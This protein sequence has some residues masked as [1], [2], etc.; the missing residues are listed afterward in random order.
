VSEKGNIQLSPERYWRISVVCTPFQNLTGRFFFTR[1]I[2]EI[3]EG[4]STDALV[5]LYRKDRRD[6][7]QV[8]PA[9]VSGN[10]KEGFLETTPLRNGYYCI[11]IRR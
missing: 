6:S 4:T 10:E 11:G 9:Q 5:L 8:L 1:S 2:S 3:P 7:W